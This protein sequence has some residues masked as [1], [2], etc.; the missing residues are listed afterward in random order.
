MIRLYLFCLY[1][2][3]SLVL[4]ED[5]ADE[6]TRTALGK[7][8]SEWNQTYRLTGASAIDDAGYDALKAQWQRWQICAGESAQADALPLPENRAL[9]PHPY[10]HRRLRKG[11]ADS[12]GRWFSRQQGQV[13]VQ[14]KV[15]GV[16]ATLIYRNGK[17]AAAI[18][19]GDGIQGQDW[20]QAVQAMPNIPQAWPTEAE[21]VLQ[22]ELYWRAP[23][24]YNAGD[25]AQR[26]AVM[27]VL[28]NEAPDSDDLNQIGFFPWDYPQGSTTMQ[29]RLAALSAA[30]FDVE[31]WTIAVNNGAEIAQLRKR[32]AEAALPF[33]VDGIVLK[34]DT[35]QESNFRY[36]GERHDA[37]AWKFASR[38]AVTAVDWVEFTVG[39]RGEITPL[40][41]L[42]PV[43]IGG[44][45]ISRV[46]MGS[47]ANWQRQDVRP[48]DQVSI[49]LNGSV[50]PYLKDVVWRT[51]HRV[52]IDIPD[53]QYDEWT[54]IDYSPDCA[55]QFTARLAWL[56]GK[57]GLN[58]RGIGAVRWQDLARQGAI[59]HILDWLDWSAADMRQFDGFGKKRAGKWAAQ[60]A[61]AK[62]RPQIDW[63]IALGLPVN[64]DEWQSWQQ[65]GLP[66]NLRNLAALTTNDWQSYPGIGKQRAISLIRF[67]DEWQQRGWT[68][69]LHNAG[70]IAF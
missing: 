64:R 35:Q 4:G 20:T 46:S 62:A 58:L 43:T 47:L 48:H 42:H 26:S 7:Q 49:A 19:R 45:K 65:D 3:S 61:V 32:W 10:P 25:R 13:Y 28:Q 27:S 59:H 21:T 29:A 31:N 40:L 24:I 53:T 23:F 15:D 9:L 33:A 1:F 69:R 34:K 54:C 68:Q 30:G 12:V 41:H 17:L 5:C 39:R 6:I 38:S 66:D 8:L 57:D 18:S 52:A 37:I 63:L 70:V 60:F 67:F 51:P 22:G 44:R 50:I 36:N 16:A 2:F 55:G 56:S 14:P 11:N